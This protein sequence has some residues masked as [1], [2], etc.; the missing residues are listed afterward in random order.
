MRKFFRYLFNLLLVL[1]AF[2]GIWSYQ[3]N[4]NVQQ[5]TNKSFVTFKQHLDQIFNLDTSAKLPTLKNKNVNPARNEA[6]DTDNKKAKHTRWKTASAY[7]YIDI[8]NDHQLKSAAI[9]AMNAW[10]RTGAFTFVQTNS[11]KKA[12]ILVTVMDDSDSEAAGQTSTT[13]NPETNYLIKAHVELNR[14]YLQ[15]PWYNYSQT[16][17]VN[18]A[19]HELGHAIGLSHKNSVSVMYPKGSYYTIQPQDVRKVE[20]IYKN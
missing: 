6:T 11:R 7:V 15:S 10:N 20:K 9:D 1:I 19:E 4:P 13:Y 14:Y 18:T 12:Q 2:W 3:N 8:N 17:I 16:R 5:A